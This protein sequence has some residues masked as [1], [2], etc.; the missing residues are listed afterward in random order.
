MYYDNCTSDIDDVFYI[1]F[2]IFDSF[3][4]II[5][6]NSFTILL[7]TIFRCKLRRNIIFGGNFTFCENNEFINL[8]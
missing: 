7:G 6:S 8:F 5:T 3:L 4:G 2:T 1:A